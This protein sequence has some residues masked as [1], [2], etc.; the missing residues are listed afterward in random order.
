MIKHIELEITN[1]C[2]LSCPM[3]PHKIMERKQGFMSFATL[4]KAV[5]Q[6]SELGAKTCYMHMIGE[7]LLHPELIP[8]INY[9]EQI[10]I[11]TS[12][13]T[14][15]V[16]LTR[17]M[18]EQLLSSSL[19][20]L[21]LAIDSLDKNT[22][23]KLREGANFENV[24]NNI[25]DCLQIALDK[26]T[27]THIQLQVIVMQDNVHE[28][29]LF[30]KAYTPIMKRVGE[31]LIKSYSTFAG[32][33]PDK[34]P[35]KTESHRDRCSKLR[36]STAILWN[37]DVVICCRDFDGKTVVGNINKQSLKHILNSDKYNVYRKAKAK[38]DFKTLDF[39]KDC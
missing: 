17:D 19:S 25:D 30:K 31:L 2:Q 13:S 38:K 8:M 10:G 15:G 33:V 36:N 37:G 39:C 27:K 9:V 6:A 29:P 20:E 26:K 24:K 21:T 11:R 18:S 34:S 32:A 3:C 12:I 16:S 4:K 23:E 22:Y 5:T 14:N 35:V 1:V 7:P 28:I